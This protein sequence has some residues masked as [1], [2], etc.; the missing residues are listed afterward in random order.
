MPGMLQNVLQV[1]K[2]IVLQMPDEAVEIIHTGFPNVVWITTPANEMEVGGLANDWLSERKL[3]INV[4]YIFSW[5][6]IPGS[7][8]HYRFAFVLTNHAE[9]FKQHWHAY[10]VSQ[11]N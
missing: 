5:Q 4:D 1:A 7:R 3:R 10:L 2:S 9:L 6:E 11:D 8:D